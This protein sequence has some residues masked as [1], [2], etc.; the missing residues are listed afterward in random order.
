M[1]NRS[2]LAAIEIGGLILGAVM[3]VFDGFTESRGPTYIEPCG[4]N[5]APAGRMARH[6]TFPIVRVNETKS[7]KKRGRVVSMGWRSPPIG[8]LP[9]E[10]HRGHRG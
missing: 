7:P 4:V 6:C 10:D 3:L 2:S 1:R 9:I 8:R 5:D